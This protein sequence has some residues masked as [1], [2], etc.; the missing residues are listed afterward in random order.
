MTSNVLI[1][2]NLPNS[3]ASAKSAIAST[4][5]VNSSE[6]YRQPNSRPV[7]RV[8]H[9]VRPLSGDQNMVAGTEVALIF[10]L[11]AKAGQAGEE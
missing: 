5:E 7:C 8:R 1:R 11:N 2:S 10:A 9:P 6:V 4:P 3:D